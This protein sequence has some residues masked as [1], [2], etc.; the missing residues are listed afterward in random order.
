MSACVQFIFY[1]FMTDAPAQTE[2]ALR[3]L[4]IDDEPR[5]RNALTV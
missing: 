4:V 3:V 1:E 5:I 2:R